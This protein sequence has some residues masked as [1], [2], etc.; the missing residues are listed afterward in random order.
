V[1]GPI[2]QQSESNDSYECHKDQANSFHAGLL[3]TV[4]LTALERKSIQK[5]QLSRK[6]RQLVHK[7]QRSDEQRERATKDLDCMQIAAEALI[8]AQ[9]RADTKSRQ[10]K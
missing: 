7:N 10:Q 1:H 6:P 4:H 8:E 3:I 5:P 9:E 2:H